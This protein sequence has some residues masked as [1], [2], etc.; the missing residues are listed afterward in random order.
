M[1]VLAF[2]LL[3]FIPVCAKA[4]A[5]WA[6]LYSGCDSTKYARLV[7]SVRV[8]KDGQVDKVQFLRSNTDT[9]SNAT[10]EKCKEAL[11]KLK[12]DSTRRGEGKF[13]FCIKNK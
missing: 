3:T 13:T 4:Q 8:S 10:I 12:F 1:K 7:F 6:S 2:L 9:V 5:D 11:H